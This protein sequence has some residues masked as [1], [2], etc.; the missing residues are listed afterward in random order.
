M[1]RNEECEGLPNSRLLLERSGN[2]FSIAGVVYIY[3]ASM[4]T[5]FQWCGE[6]EVLPPSPTRTASLKLLFNFGMPIFHVSFQRENLLLCCQQLWTMSLFT[7]YIRSLDDFFFRI[8]FRS[9]ENF[10]G[11]IAMSALCENSEALTIPGQKWDS[12]LQVKID[13]LVWLN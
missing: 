7:V 10:G 9:E 11:T 5:T 12:L 4:D 1:W 13:R 6:N 3:M 2:H 8:L